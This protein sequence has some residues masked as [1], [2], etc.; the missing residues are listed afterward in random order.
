MAAQ[1][2]EGKRMASHIFSTLNA[3][4]ATHELVMQTKTLVWEFLQTKYG[5]E[6]GGSGGADSQRLAAEKGILA[7]DF[8]N[9]ME[10]KKWVAEAHLSSSRARVEQGFE[11]YAWD[12]IG[13][14]VLS[15]LFGLSSFMQP[16]RDKAPGARRSAIEYWDPDADLYS[17]GADQSAAAADWFDEIGPRPMMF[18]RTFGDEER[19]NI[20]S[21]PFGIKVEIITLT[22]DRLRYR[23]ASR[24]HFKRDPGYLEPHEQVLVERHLE[25]ID[26]AR[27]A[28][29]FGEG[30]GTSEGE[31]LDLLLPDPGSD[32]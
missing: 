30:A 10:T 8:Y 25:R 16:E 27:S 22:A 19:L 24:V 17:E 31:D 28:K 9:F 14:V 32:G 11:H 1:N 5:S 13:H 7:G 26:L 3:N 18:E 29:V 6:I 4:F 15:N 12:L 20:R 21:T 2:A 23:T